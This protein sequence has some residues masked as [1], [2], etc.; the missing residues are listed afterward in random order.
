MSIAAYSEWSF[1]TS[2][3]A[4]SSNLTAK[5]NVNSCF[6]LARALLVHFLQGDREV[7]DILV[8]CSCSQRIVVYKL[9]NTLNVLKFVCLLVGLKSC[10][11]GTL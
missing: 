11:T 10:A 8:S 7:P 5:D 1:E 3:R 6:R 4:T 2:V 9:K